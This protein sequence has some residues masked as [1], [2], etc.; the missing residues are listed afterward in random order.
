[1]FRTFKALANAS[2]MASDGL[3]GRVSTFLF[4]DQ[5]WNVLYLAIELKAWLERREVVV[6]ISQVEHVD[7][8]K[9]V[10]RVRLSKTQVRNSPGIDSARPVNR[11]QEIALRN[12]FGWPAR[13][14]QVAGEFS[15]PSFAAGREYPVQGSDNPHL[16]STEALEGYDVWDRAGNIGRL[17]NFVVDDPSW[18]ISFLEVKAGDWLHS[19]FVL[20]STAQ[21]ELVSWAKYRVKVKT[22]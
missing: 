11:Q 21:V 9:K 17:W 7:W 6:S 15:L 20:V 14:G 19:R 22:A 2:V 3:V 4:D 13:W 8:E 1:M 5:S 10:V 18:H 12:Y 16:R